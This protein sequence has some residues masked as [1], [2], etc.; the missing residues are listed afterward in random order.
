M[1]DSQ[2]SD[3]T[4]GKEH[5]E[6]EPTSKSNLRLEFLPPIFVLP[7]HL[8][9]EELHRAEDELS[10]HGAPLTYDIT[11]ARIVL[12]NIAKER[13]AK[14]ELQW[15]NVM[16]DE[17]DNPMSET[18]LEATVEE[19]RNVPATKRRKLNKNL[20]SRM[21]AAETTSS[22]GSAESETENEEN[23]SVKPLSQLS[24]SHVE[25]ASVANISDSEASEKSSSSPFGLDSFAG[26]VKVVKLD[27]FFE[28]LAKGKPQPLEPFTVYE[29]KLLP[30][31]KSNVL[32]QNA[33]TTLA[34]RL[35][36]PAAVHSP[37]MEENAVHE[38]VERAQADAKPHFPRNQRRDRVTDAM[39]NDFTGRSFLHAGGSQNQPF[40]RPS[41][42]LHQTTSEHDEGMSQALPEMPD[43]VLQKKIYSCERSTPLHCPNE[44]FIE[45][46][47]SIKLA[48][49]LTGDEIGVRAYSTSIA[50]I[51]AYPHVI[52]SMKEVLELP[53]CDQKIAYLFHEWQASGGTIQAVADIE[54]DQ[55]LT[56]LRQ[57][58]EIWGVGAKTARE[59]YY[60][61]GWR[62]LDDI[63][64]H[65]WKSLQRVQQIGLKYY[66][67]F[68]LKMQR[69]EVETIAAV[70][71]EHGRRVTDSGLEYIIVG[72][73]RRGKDKCG[74]VDIILSHR[75]EHQTYNLV[76]RVTRSLEKEGWITH[77]LT[78]NLTNT[79]RDQQPL[80]LAPL[81]G[82]H[83]F[84]T[85]DKALVVWQSQDWPTQ[86]ADLAVN[87]KA[88][89]QHPHRRVDIIV[90]PWRTVGCAIAGWTSGTTFQRDLRRY[91]KNVKG[92]KFDSSGV[93]ERGSGRWVDL[94]E[95]GDPKKRAPTWQVAER[96]VFEGLG[97][98][99]R[100]PW[101]RCT[102]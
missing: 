36:R 64:E 55:V 20:E 15:A 47:S 50:S 100:E 19:D 59:F 83:G 16:I 44:K 17:S 93:R 39:K 88:K 26:K 1:T 85:L 29:A 3:S 74:D 92:W 69:S 76:D 9:T 94:E 80:P 65:G 81:A 84:D 37:R 23:T 96:R 8:S 53:G 77:T 32:A 90:S 72:G 43:W 98:V 86:S 101:E 5:D 33:S 21:L 42:L 57:F 71:A 61:Q 99:Y 46:L 89:N 79:K 41:K 68:Q 66:D 28:S 7:L 56:V 73:Y 11:E 24:I 22:T 82:G 75:D 49:L 102:G 67:E 97:L 12:G 18:L 34:A 78:V 70:V 40:T 30:P 52:T 91:V 6:L 48:R 10:C 87:P 13:R 38:I 31:Q 58:Y 14:L 2:A 51:A 25:K 63:V 62:E 95:W 45:Q 54:S 27:W 35:S 60:D 4:V